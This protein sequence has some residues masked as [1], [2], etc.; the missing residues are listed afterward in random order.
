MTDPRYKEEPEEV[1]TLVTLRR[2]LDAANF[3]LR[4]LDRAIRLPVTN[5]LV[6]I[7]GVPNAMGIV[8]QTDGP[9]PVQPGMKL[10]VVLPEGT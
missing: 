5:V 6:E 8:V 7:P 10:L 3:R 9:L 1:E 2:K 4:E